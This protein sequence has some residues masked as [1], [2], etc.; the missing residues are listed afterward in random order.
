MDNNITFSIVIPHKNIPQLLQ[1]CLKSIPRRD[2]IQIIVVDDNSD[3][4]IVNFN[5][6]PGMGEKCV[7]LYFAKEGKGAGYARNIALKHVKGKWILFADAD[8][9][10]NDGFLEIID[11]Y[12]NSKYDIIYFGVNG[13]TEQGMPSYR[14]YIYD[15]LLTNAISKEDLY[16]YYFQVY[17]PWGKLFSERLMMYNFLF[18]ETFVAN[19]MMFTVKTVFFAKSITYD[20]HKIYTS[21]SRPDSLIRQNSFQA[22]ITRLTVHCRVNAFLKN[23]NRFKYRIN[24]F[25][26]L[27]R[28]L[29]QGGIKVFLKGCK[30]LFSEYRSV[31]RWRDFFY[32]FEYVFL[33]YCRSKKQ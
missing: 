29:V 13:L 22:E 24:L 3:K 21:Y 15:N 2:D 17:P 6:F 25:V 12:I 28:A 10:F 7:E 9:K 32:V 19:D 11:N 18:D 16:I 14:N 20:T 23:N 31:Y 4:T 5:D 26:S 1:R 33:K 30:L 27:K 8:D